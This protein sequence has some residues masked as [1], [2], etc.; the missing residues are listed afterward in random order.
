MNGLSAGIVFFST[1]EGGVTKQLGAFD[2]RGF[3]KELAIKDGGE[4]RVTR[5]VI[6]C[7]PR[8]RLHSNLA[9]IHHG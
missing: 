4:V 9:N 1:T 2:A 6:S 7:Q 3:G 8:A 5:V